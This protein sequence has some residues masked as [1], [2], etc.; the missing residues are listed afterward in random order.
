MIPMKPVLILQNL[1]L[2]GPAYLATWLRQQGQ[3]YVVYNA[4]AGDRYP[5]RVDEFCALALLG[6]EMS[7]NDPM[8]HLRQAEA[9][10]RQ[11]LA[12]GV[13]VIGHCLG[14]Q[15]MARAMGGM[16]GRSPA[17]EIG[18][19]R[20]RYTD[21]DA[22]H[23]WFGPDPEACV[24]QWHYET[25]SL[26]PHAEPLAI[27]DVCVQQAFGCGP[28]LAMQ[29]HVELDMEKLQV[30][31][32]AKYERFALSLGVSSVQTVDEMLEVAEERL[33]CQQQLASQIYGRWL[34]AAG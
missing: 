3:P 14:G 16:V 31:T 20:I 2:D 25:F 15:L 19:H 21:R 23:D 28:H 7:A 11:S 27:G 33:A 13:P 29:F 34:G 4:E 6:G 17:P 12:A 10:V 18:W 26:P 1:F 24:F 8:P 32:R 22:A 9:L 5:E 30:W